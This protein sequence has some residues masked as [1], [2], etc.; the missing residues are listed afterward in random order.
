[1]LFR[2]RRM[3]LTVVTLIMV[4]GLMLPAYAAADEDALSDLSEVFQLLQDYHIHDVLGET[5][6]SEAI[7]A[8]LEAVDDPYTTYYSKDEWE[9]YQMRMNQQYSGVGMRLGEDQLGFYVVEVFDQSPAHISGMQSG[10]YIIAVDGQSAQ[11]LTLEQLVDL[12]V[13]VKGTEVTLEVDRNGE[14]LSITCTRDDIQVPVVFSQR[15]NGNLGYI[16]LN[17]F[18]ESADE[19]FIQAKHSLEAEGI[20]GLIIDV[21]GNPGGY[22]HIVSNIAREFIAEGVLIYQEDRHQV[23]DQTD[24]IGGQEVSYPVVLLVD[25]HSASG[26]EI[27]AGALQDYNLATIIGEVTYGKGYIQRL[28]QLSSGS[29]LRMTIEQYLTPNKHPVHEVGITPD[30]IVNGHVPQVLAALHVLEQQTIEMKATAH[31]LKVNG[32]SVVGLID[33]IS[34]EDRVFVHSRQLA[35]LNDATVAWDDQARAVQLTKEDET[36][37]FAVS[38]P[39]VRLINGKTYISLDEYTKAFKNVHW[40]LTDDELT[41]TYEQ[42]KE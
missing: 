29:Y 8:M 27:L 39:Y 2:I 37:T 32:A 15:L 34:E 30:L 21:R 16:E 35:A 28:I 42:G 4:V 11:A 3:C 14:K 38:S 10:D 40:S 23:T 33:S 19:A 12:I 9:A 5:L 24:I 17:S 41:I 6:A 22:L 25:E 31:S 13:G 7:E 26:S 36:I 20:D 18:N 1:M